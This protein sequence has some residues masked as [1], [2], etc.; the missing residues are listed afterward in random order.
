VN[1]V[2]LAATFAPKV[3][4]K[5]LEVFF[6][7]DLVC[8]NRQKRSKCVGHNLAIHEATRTIAFEKM[9]LP[10]VKKTLLAAALSAV[11]FAATPASA[12]TIMFDGCAEAALCGQLSL[13]TTL[14]GNV[15]D[16]LVSAPAGYG[17]FGS[18]GNNHALGFNVVGSQTGLAISN[19][20]A[21][22]TFGGTDGQLNGDGFFEYLIDGPQSGSDALLPLTFTVS[23][24]GGFS[25]DLAL[26]ETNALGYIAAAHLR[27]ERTGVTGYVTSGN[28][29]ATNTPVPEPATMMLVGSGLVVACRARKARA[30]LTP[31]A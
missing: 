30:A 27:N 17:V 22:F 19:L 16:V 5:A 8:V 29:P 25:S 28:Q 23:R 4:W 13:T 20:S 10:Y 7:N 6:V 18:T 2:E 21:G 26:F 14:N 15:I 9:E 11:F 31:R 1:K 12:A 24:T 3:T